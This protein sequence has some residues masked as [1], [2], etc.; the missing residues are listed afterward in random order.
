MER[1]PD[2]VVVVP[3]HPFDLG[4]YRLLG[5]DIDDISP[6][7]FKTDLWKFRH[8][9]LFGPAHPHE[10]RV[11]T[12]AHMAEIMTAILSAGTHYQFM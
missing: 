9:D 12:R 7:K 11:Q 8:R 6:T 10:E 5:F 1:E 4:Q 2:P 3:G